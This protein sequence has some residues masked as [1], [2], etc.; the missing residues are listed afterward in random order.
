MVNKKK[1]KEQQPKQKKAM[2]R[3]FRADRQVEKEKQGWKK[4]TATAEDT[5]KMTSKGD[6]VLMEKHV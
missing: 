2:Q 1:E 6:L 3:L 5:I 4:I